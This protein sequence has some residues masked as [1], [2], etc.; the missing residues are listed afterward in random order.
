MRRD[1]KTKY[2]FLTKKNW[3]LIER[4]VYLNF[5]WQKNAEKCVLYLNTC[6]ELKSVSGFNTNLKK[7]LLRI[8]D[9]LI[10]IKVDRNFNLNRFGKIFLNDIF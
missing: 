8:K 6:F 7:L 2:L 1:F 5:Y 9:G 10:R 4:Y 3:K